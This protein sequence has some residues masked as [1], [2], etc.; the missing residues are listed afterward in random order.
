MRPK[1]DFTYT[2]SCI[3]RQAFLS[4]TAKTLGFRSAHFHP[5]D[6]RPRPCVSHGWIIWDRPL[7]DKEIE[8][9][10]LLTGLEFIVPH[11]H[12]GTLGF[13][14]F[15]AIDGAYYCYKEGSYSHDKNPFKIR[16]F[17]LGGDGV[18]LPATQDTN[19]LVMLRDPYFLHLQRD[20]MGPD[21][22]KEDHLCFSK[23]TQQCDVCQTLQ[24]VLI[25]YLSHTQCFICSSCFT[26][27]MTTLL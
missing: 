7:D 19:N 3:D 22:Q 9:W 17:S 6:D 26:T 14:S 12:T 23:S 20:S 18:S 16:T 5:R 25:I 8:E 27:L 4:P 24:K 10:K 15:V 11:P 1:N 21:G 13:F 2:L